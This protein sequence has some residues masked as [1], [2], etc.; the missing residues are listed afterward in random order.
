[1][2]LLPRPAR[3]MLIILVTVAL[4]S[5]VLALAPPSPIGAPAA[6]AKGAPAFR[7]SLTTIAGAGDPAVTDRGCETYG[8]SA[9]SN[10]AASG[11][12]DAT[13][14]DA[15]FSSPF[16]VALS[17]DQKTLYVSDYGN[18]AIR[19]VDVATGGVST[20]I[21]GGEVFQPT[22]LA[23][24]AS[25]AVFVV[26][27]ERD[28]PNA[29]HPNSKILRIDGCGA[30]TIVL[31]G[32][33][34]IGGIATDGT[35]LWAA[36]ANEPW[37]AQNGVLVRLDTSAHYVGKE[38]LPEP[39]WTWWW[40]LAF[41]PEAIAVYPDGTLYVQGWKV[42][43]RDPAA[44]H[45]LPHMEGNDAAIARTGRLYLSH[46]GSCPEWGNFVASYKA[47]MVEDR[48]VIAGAN[49]GT[50]SGDYEDGSPGGMCNPR[51]VALSRD[52]ST[53][54]VADQGN[55]AIR[56][57]KVA[58]PTIYAFGLS[59]AFGY[60]ADPVNTFTGNYVEQHTDLPAPAE[61]YGMDWSRT[62]NHQDRD[63]HDLGRGWVHSFDERV[64]AT[65]PSDLVEYRAADG[66]VFPFTRPAG[67]TQAVWESAGIRGELRFDSASETFR[68]ALHNGEVHIF[69]RDGRVV[70]LQRARTS[71]RVDVE[72]AADRIVRASGSGGYRLDFVYDD[73][74]SLIDRVVASDGRSVDY[75][76]DETAFLSLVTGP[77]GTATRYVSDEVG[78][79]T[80]VWQPVAAGERLMLTNEFDGEDRIVVQSVDPNDLDGV[81]DRA[82]F[83]YDTPTAGR[84]TVTSDDGAGSVETLV[85]THDEDG[86]LVGVQDPLGHDVTRTWDDEQ[87]D[88]YTD[89]SDATYKNG[90]DRRGRLCKRWLTDPDTG[91]IGSFETYRYQGQSTACDGSG[92]DPRLAEH[93]DATG[94][95]T[96]YEYDVDDTDDVPSRIVEAFGTEVAATTELRSEDGLISQ[97]TDP[98]G[99][100]T[101]YA[102]DTVS[103]R[104]LSRTVGDATT[105]FGYDTVG[106]QTVVRSAMGVE[107]WTTFDAEGRPTDQIGPL[108]IDRSCPP[109][110]C[111][112][113]P[114]P[115]AAI[116]PTTHLEYAPDG[117]LASKT[118]P[119]GRTWTYLTMYLS[120]GGRE[121]HTTDPGGNIATSRYDRAGRLVVQSAPNDPNDPPGTSTTTTYVYGPLGR[122]VRTTDPTGGQ[123]HYCYDAS[124]RTTVVASGVLSGD[125]TIDCTSPQDALTWT[126]TA[127][128]KRG[129][130]AISTTGRSRSEPGLETRY[131]YDEA[132]RLVEAIGP[133]APTV[134]M[135]ARPRTST[136]Y[137]ARG[138]AIRATDATGGVVETTFTP[139]GKVSGTHDVS[140]GLHTKNGYDVR[141]GQLVEVRGAA[142]DPFAEDAPVTR[143]AYDLDD[144]V[145]RVTQPD[146][147]TSETLAYDASGRVLRS[148]DVTGVISEFEW[149]RS[150]DLARQVTA[151]GTGDAVDIRFDAH[152]F[153]GQVER[154][155]DGLGNTTSFEYSTRG[156]RS[157]VTNALGNTARWT[158][159][160]SGRETTHIDELGRMTTTAYDSHGRVAI[161]TTPDGRTE[162][163]DWNASG[164]LARVTSTYGAEAQTVTYSYDDLG[165]RREMADPTGTSTY[166]YDPSD[167]LTGVSAPDGRST[168]WTYDAAGRRTAMA[169]PDG[170]VLDYRYDP[171]T[172][173]LSTV[174]SRSRVADTFTGPDGSDVDKAKWTTPGTTGTVEV[175]DRSAELSVDRGQTA[176]LQYRAS[177]KLTNSDLALRYRFAG[178]AA[179]SVLTL[180]SRQSTTKNYRLTVGTGAST[181]EL[182]RTS[183]GASTKLGELPVG[184]G[185]QWQRVRFEVSGSRVRARTWTDGQGEPAVWGLDVTDSAVT[186]TGQVAAS[187]T[188]PSGADRAAV[189]LDDVTV[190]DASVNP[191]TPLV[192]YEWDR[193]GRPT[194]QVTP[195][196]DRS[197]TYLDGRLHSMTQNLPGAVSS[198]ELGYDAA[199]RLSS[200]T[201]AGAT[202]SYDY[203]PAGQLTAVTRP[204]T[205]E[206][207]S[208]D[209]LGRRRTK[210]VDGA[211]TTYNYDAAS[212]LLSTTGATAGTYSWDR[213]GRL[214][215]AK[216][217]AATTAYTFDVAGRLKS[218]RRGGIQANRT[219]NGDGQLTAVTGASGS[220]TRVDWDVAAPLPDVSML[221]S[222]SGTATA[223][224]HESDGASAMY[225]GDDGEGLP[226]DVRGSVLKTG[227]AS[228]LAVASGYDAFG[229]TA[230]THSVSDVKL[231]Y[232]G[233]LAESGL[234][235]LR[236]RHYSAATG[237]FTSR[238]PLDGVDGTPTVS[239]PYHYADNDPLN[240]IDPTGLRPDDHG[241][242]GDA[243]PS[244]MT[245]SFPVD[246]EHRWLG[247]IHI[248]G[249]I[250]QA[251][252]SLGPGN[253]FGPRYF[254]GD[255]RDF[256]EAGQTINPKEN[257]FFA[258]VDFSSGT[259]Y[260]QVNPTCR[261]DHAEPLLAGAGVVGSAEVAFGDWGRCSSGL[262]TVYGTYGGGSP[263]SSS[264]KKNYWTV[265]R[266]G[267]TYRFKWSVVHSD[268]GAGQDAFRARADGNLDFAFKDGGSWLEPSWTGDCFPSLEVMRRA[269]G[270]TQ[271]IGR[272]SHAG[273]SSMVGAVTWGN[274]LIGR[275]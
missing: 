14:F 87:P 97:S 65:A 63:Q 106:R 198:T 36:V 184:P 44:T 144:R 153:D 164:Q 220:T 61:A 231:G 107:T 88:E 6:D 71:E 227:A 129:R 33:R 75:T 190:G 102:W 73:D 59:A 70:R 69:D 81:G 39:A 66:R 162:Q 96:R 230:T 177:P 204:S 116:G 273:A 234:V 54:Y 143:Y 171:S 146:G 115:A 25:G 197:S 74:D 110:A 99:V 159:D 245:F 191:G 223:F 45:Q 185:D 21:A 49:S 258:R 188:S 163:R 26:S 214:L 72:W 122:L 5:G 23:V 104:M 90:Y 55:H 130:V 219:V 53:L 19:R 92:D 4:C 37:A 259:G 27:H 38:S 242:W 84:T 174:D 114:P 209:E 30:P 266:S 111:E 167:R 181:A 43:P 249:F 139:A 248:A 145:V 3:R 126:S 216:V 152:R 267:D 183:A 157:S 240:K 76:Q 235:N 138:R 42:D 160:S 253:D 247:E 98:D 93:V 117:S 34:N 124:G 136:A 182:W 103:R 254:T 140:T 82:T 131:R 186:G 135:E 241:F 196:G 105:W 120:G 12:V 274:T 178:D 100:V 244:T 262:P 7:Q 192:R 229:V 257:R 263:T 149:T 270:T 210:A 16:D 68:L 155:R 40:G 142:A 243:R 47:S 118:D 189:N 161:V 89:R 15:R 48:K 203:D 60:S 205:S 127:Y 212:Q 112:F 215:S 195:D 193:V 141:T 225:S 64:L 179:D 222:S 180:A 41:Y 211:T 62:Y 11:N 133:A 20:C 123:T 251:E 83:A 246:E 260:V 232:R 52:N 208:Y 151:P 175:V 147:T 2:A 134:S 50:W 199:G 269:E 9:P 79:V 218:T 86:L 275:C 67:S 57:I 128:D 121:E 22:S 137:D 132:D 170:T 169:L 213:V 166:A 24:D 201:S 58:K 217:G 272:V 18:D 264:Y 10:C 28:V 108:R 206:R 31:D 17:P 1:M 255:D 172:G 32:V 148:K 125:S 35:G 250:N 156:Q 268:M 173:R 154:A 109:T 94:M 119:E 85:Y 113:G 168:L 226:V 8:T 238:D 224:V 252:T 13:G 237:T 202:T 194:R 261:I 158:Y 271:V 265:Q 80:E 233:E 46:G 239:N 187:L 56:K 221:T 200:E 95:V 228:A 256:T 236:A 207:Y 150:G 51:G 77:A 101:S 165:R 29:D 91:G 176:V 78:R